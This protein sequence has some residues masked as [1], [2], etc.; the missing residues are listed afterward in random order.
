MQKIGTIKQIII[1]VQEMDK[2]VRFYRDILQLTKNYP[3]GLDSYATEGWVTFGT[4]EASL[5]LHG[6]GY[7]DFGKDAPKFTFETDDI[8]TTKK[9][10]ESNQISTSDIR[11]PAPDV[12]V[13]DAIDPEG[14]KFSLEQF[15]VNT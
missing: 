3:A 10:L 4:G 12:R 2:Q 6:G 7:Q 13:F 9:Y 5:C 14:N 11:S 8:E 1:Y 15:N